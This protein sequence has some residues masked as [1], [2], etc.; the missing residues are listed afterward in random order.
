MT[1]TNEHETALAVPETSSLQ[2]LM[3]LAD[4]FARSGFFRDATS[5]AKAV[6]KIMAGRELGIAPVSSMT[7]I[8]IV[9][10]KIE[11]GAEIMAALVKR[12]GEYDYLVK[13]HDDTKCSIE[14]QQKGQTVYTSVF[15]LKDA[16]RAGV[17]RPGSGWQKFPR[18]MLFAR[19]MSQ[20]ARI[21]CPHLIAGAYIEG[22]IGAFPQE[23]IE[24]EA[25][26]HE[27]ALTEGQLQS[28]PEGSHHPMVREELA[29]A[30]LKLG[31][32]KGDPRIKAALGGVDVDEWI[33]LGKSLEDAY[34][35][36]EQYAGQKAS[37]P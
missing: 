2:D 24:A 37:T 10:G 30:A 18:A 28:Q 12:S 26:K 33:K 4:A 9:E 27:T 21:A 7:K 25:E 17:V 16:E 14:F 8:H 23:Q 1:N 19:A 32:K 22:E 29:R 3:G 11:I 13:E 36:L 15:T 34:L 5:A 35:A 20:G 6:V 31:Y